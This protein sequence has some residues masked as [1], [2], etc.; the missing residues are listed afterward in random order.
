MDSSINGIKTSTLSWIE[1]WLLTMEKNL[2]LN[3]CSFLASTHTQTEATRLFQNL[4]DLLR[5]IDKRTG[6][7]ALVAHARLTELIIGEHPIAVWL[8]GDRERVRRVKRILSRAPF[9]A[10]YGAIREAF[11][12]EIDFRYGDEEAMGLGL[13]YWNDSLSI[14][15]DRDPWRAPMLPLRL[16]LLQETADGDIVERENEVQ[17]R[18]ATAVEHVEVHADWIDTYRVEVPRTP[19]ELWHYRAR[20]YPNVLF[21]PPVRSQIQRLGGASPSFGQV[22]EKLTALQDSLSDWNG[23]GLPNWQVSVTGEYQQREKFCWFEDLDGVSRLFEDHTKFAPGAGRIHF[24]L[25]GANK[26]IIV[27]YVGRKLGI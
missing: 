11:H 4:F 16:F 13:S 12:G 14:G 27:A 24:R 22:V 5:Y 8:D 10:D 20:W 19:D 3:E 2:Y 23:T 7:L 15:V 9:D 26:R 21:L 17:C 18:H 25:D 6:G 1:A